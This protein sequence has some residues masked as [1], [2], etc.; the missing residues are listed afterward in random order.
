MSI[1]QNPIKTNRASDLIVNQI[2]TSGVKNK[3]KNTNSALLH[4]AFHTNQSQKQL[5]SST[6]ISQAISIKNKQPKLSIASVASLKHD[7]AL[8]KRKLKVHNV[9]IEPDINESEALAA[10]S[11]T[12]DY[13]IINS[14]TLNELDVYKANLIKNSSVMI[15][16]DYESDKLQVEIENLKRMRQDYGTDWLLSTPNLLVNRIETLKENTD[17]TVNIESSSECVASAVEKDLETK[18]ADSNIIESFVVYRMICVGDEN[19]VDLND[20]IIKICIVSLNDKYLIEKDE[21]DTEFLSVN[22]LADITDIKI[23]KQEWE[24]YCFTLLL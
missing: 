22:Q 19:I 10:K 9:L 4:S 2:I 17:E 8:I 16:K 21:T 20:L 23:A 18:L 12:N 3:Q 24:T 13:V 6:N 5:T 14:L 11:L 7:T 1:N 15:G